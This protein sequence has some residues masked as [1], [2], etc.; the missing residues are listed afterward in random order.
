[1][2]GIGPKTNPQVCI[3]SHTPSV[4]I[5][6]RPSVLYLLSLQVVAAEGNVFH[7]IVNDK[8]SEYFVPE[9]VASNFHE[10]ILFRYRGPGFQM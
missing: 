7:F 1:M 4:F 10:K 9:N 3:F 6:S 5:F 2:L 8:A